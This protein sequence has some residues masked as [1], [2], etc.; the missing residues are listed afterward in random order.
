MKLE[1]TLPLTEK[2]E[3]LLAEI[4]RIDLL[5]STLG[6]P[7]PLGDAAAVEPIIQD[8][9]RSQV[10]FIEREEQRRLQV[11]RYAIDRELQELEAAKQ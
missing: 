2:Q 9:G 4:E 3:K 5:L 6:K 11:L 8:T 1:L 7:L 10:A